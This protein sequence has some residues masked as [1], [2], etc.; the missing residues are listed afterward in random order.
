MKIKDYQLC[1]VADNFAWF[2]DNFKNQW[3]DDW[4]DAPYQHNA[5]EPYDSDVNGKPI[6]HVKVGF[7][8]YTLHTPED[9]NCVC[10][11]KQINSG[12]YPWFDKPRYYP[13]SK[14]AIYA[15]TTLDDFLNILD[16]ENIEYYLKPKHLKQ[17][18]NE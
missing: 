14:P 15:G 8:D 10:S 5:G 13:S 1:Y 3:G 6:N 18:E 17:L 12:E 9:N 4:N 11:V 16:L 2:T 7:D